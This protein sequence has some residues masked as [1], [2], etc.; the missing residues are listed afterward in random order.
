MI[1]RVRLFV[2]VNVDDAVLRSPFAGE[3]SDELI[4]RKVREALGAIP[5]VTEA[6]AI[7][8]P[9]MLVGDGD[10]I[11]AEERTSSASLKERM[12]TTW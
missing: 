1:R 12:N 3:L 8:L 4:R 2:E 10:V 5:G 9:R 11:R 7:Y 6:Q